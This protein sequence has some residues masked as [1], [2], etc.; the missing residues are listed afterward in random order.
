MSAFFK[1]RWGRYR[2]VK[3]A[4]S[5]R[6]CPLCGNND[7]VLVSR[8]DRWFNPLV[9]VMCRRC[10]LVFL[11]PMPTDQELDQY[12]RDQF[13][14]RSRQ[15]RTDRKDHRQGDALFGRTTIPA[16]AGPAARH[17]HSRRRRRRRRVSVSG[18]DSRSRASSRAS[19]MRAIAGRHTG[20]TFMPRRS[21]IPNSA[22]KRSISSPATIRSSTCA[23]RCAR[24]SA[25]TTISSPMDISMCRCPIW[26]IRTC[27]GI[28]MPVTCAAS[29]MKLW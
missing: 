10:G 2:R 12:Y 28:F 25:C 14:S 29:A 11:D 6:P 9:N 21:P 22:T 23:I 27:C 8:F 16:G 24:L 18:A 20:S 15:R 1:I 5:H 17:A 26:V 13:W 7:A 4:G 19:A 3:F